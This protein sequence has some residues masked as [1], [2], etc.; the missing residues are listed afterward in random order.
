MALATSTVV[1]MAV[2]AAAAA[3]QAAETQRVARKQDGQAADAIRNQSAKQRE[4]DAK[5][6]EEVG[7]L[8]GSSSG[9]EKAKRM[10]DYSAMLR[11]N[12]AVQGG[13]LSAPIVGSQA[14]RNDAA[15]ANDDVQREGMATADLMARIDAPGMQRQGE[16]F[17][18]G[19]LATDI[20]MIGRESRGQAFLDDLKLR[21]IRR[22]PWVDVAAGVASSM[23]GAMGGGGGMGGAGVASTPAFTPVQY[24]GKAVYSSTPLTGYGRA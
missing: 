22:N 12:K 1:A 17:G 2:M 19:K 15:A 24:G 21:A 18:F 3:A 11:R 16:G 13:G 4:A 23:A 14:F 5:V 8:Q 20:S 7:K 6:N 10:A 9:D